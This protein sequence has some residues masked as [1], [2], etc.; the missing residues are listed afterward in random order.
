MSLD[1]EDKQGEERRKKELGVV[2]GFQ[3]LK[4][5]IPDNTNIKSC[6]KD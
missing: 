3:R 2:E 5:D 4:K 6:R 1:K